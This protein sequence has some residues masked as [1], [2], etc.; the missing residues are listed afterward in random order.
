MSKTFLYSSWTED[1]PV[2]TLACETLAVDFVVNTLNR[3]DMF[4]K[5]SWHSSKI[6]VMNDDDDDGDDDN[7]DDD[8][9]MM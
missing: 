5:T 1:S 2:Q 7:D 4:Q 8:D 6:M 3:N 9:V